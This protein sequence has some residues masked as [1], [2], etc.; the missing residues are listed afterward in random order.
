MYYLSIALFCSFIITLLIMN[1]GIRWLRGWQGNGQPIRDDGPQT[2]LKKSGTPTMGGILIIVCI[3]IY[4]LIFCSITKELI[5]I[6]FVMLSY[7]LIGFM[8]DYSKV[9]KQTSKGIRAKLRLVLEFVVAAVVLS[10]LNP[11]TAINVPFLSL[12]Q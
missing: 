1:W 4:S 10:I 11:P 2:H 5:I 6:L 3:S 9:K 7:G 8:D 12:V